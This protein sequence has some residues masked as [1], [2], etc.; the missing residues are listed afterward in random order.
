MRFCDVEDWA[1]NF[2]SVVG[3]ILDLVWD[4]ILG[5]AAIERGPSCW[6]LN[7]RRIIMALWA[8]VVV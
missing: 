5:D 3:Q 6:N 7:L 2:P 8:V 4:Y 1:F